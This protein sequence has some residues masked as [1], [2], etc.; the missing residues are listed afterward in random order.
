M[1][2]YCTNM[3]SGTGWQFWIDRG[4][5]F[6]DVVARAPDGVL[7]VHKLLSV[8]P[9]HYDDA[10]I[11]AIHELLKVPASTPL[12]FERIE[13]VRLGTTL[14]TNALLEHQGERT[15]LVT[16]RGFKDAVRIGYQNRPKIFDLDIRLP[17]MLYSDVVEVDERVLA[18]GTLLRPLDVVGARKALTAAHEQGYRSCA[19][20]LIHGFRFPAHEAQLAQIANDVGFSQVC[21]SHATI[22]LM[23]FVSRADTTLADAYLSPILQ[24]YVS[25]LQSKLTGVKL[26]FMQSSGGLASADK[27]R[28]KDSILSGP[29]GGIVGAAKTATACGTSKII[30]FDMGGTSTDVAHFDGKFERADETQI[31]GARIRVPMLAIHTVAAGG[32][33][34]CRFDGQRFRVGPESAGAHPGPACYRRN[35]PLTITDCNVLLGKIRGRYFPSVFGSD[36]RQPIDETVVQAR[37]KEL[38]ATV[39]ATTGRNWSEEQIARGFIRIA[40][41]QMANAIKRVSTEKGKDIAEYALQC[42]GGA[43]GQHACMLA[44]SLGIRTILIHPLAGVLSALGIGMSDVNAVRYLAV[45]EELSEECLARLEPEFARLADQARASVEAQ[46]SP[47]SAISSAVT[48]H[49]RYAGTDFALPI[50][51]TACQSMRAEFES[52]QLARYGFSQTDKKIIIERCTIEAR[53]RSEVRVNFAVETPKTAAPLETVTCFF[54]SGAEKTDIWDRASLHAG[55]RVGGPALIIDSAATTVIDPGWSCVVLDDGTLSITRTPLRDDLDLT[56]NMSSEFDGGQQLQIADPVMLEMFNNLFMF[57][58]EQM[59]VTLQNTSHSVNIKERLDFSCAIFDAEGDL[60]ANAPHIPVHLGSMGESVKEMIRRVGPDLKPGDAY[61]LNDPYNGGTHL[62]DVTVMAPYFDRSGRIA[63]HVAARGHH[64]DIGGIT[65]GSMPPDSRSIADEGV[66]IGMFQLV[67]G[68]IL[69]EQATIDLLNSSDHPARNVEQNLADLKAQIAATHRGLEEL[70]RVVDHYGIDVVSA[71]ARYVQDN[72]E[73]SVRAAIA[74]LNGGTFTC[75]MDSGARI[76]VTI[77]IDHAAKTAR[78]DFSE[79]SAQ[80]DDNFN[81]PFAVC[82]AAVLYVFRTLVDEDIPLNAGC[83]RPIEIIAPEGTMLNPRYPAAVVA[84]NVETSQVLVDAL[85][86]AL[87]VLASSQGTMNN[88]TFGDDEHQYYETICGGAGAGNGFS[89]ASAVHTHMTNSRLTDPEVIEHRFPI[90]VEEFSIRNGSGG[91]GLFRGGDGVKRKLK[92]MRPMGAAILSNRRV[93]AGFGL[94]G[95]K[96]GALGK[97]YVIRNN[98]SIEELSYRD[99]V[100][101]EIDDVIVIETPAGGGFGPPA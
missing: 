43:G 26:F 23:K 29:A 79:T 7:H 100:S 65:P 48:A 84:G 64:A 11:Q 6:T 74:R 41:Q 63:F 92:F 95:G 89:G 16:T 87:G 96:P 30:A 52:Q 72:A 27:F 22:P 13:S 51:V 21:T 19:I 45:E 75:T 93:H 28:G 49:L 81:A 58:A 71:Y 82:K 47:G 44:G 85:Y 12:P 15:L 4:G 37:F 60:I 97:N 34:I 54:D 56:G 20:I 46:M 91:A 42:F 14:A 98:G 59:G 24:R 32:G 50:E 18:D 8:D 53:G 70:D 36:G 5:T 77:T 1:V 38:A 67:D 94:Q 73:R 39:S 62:P 68:G 76:S 9:E 88:L 2:Q 55:K 80:T 83:L 101:M 78:V 31:A 61:A 3:D 57:I 99:F 17:F 90:I 25:Q 66:L 40:V 33:S 35:G 69:R 86:G 10:T